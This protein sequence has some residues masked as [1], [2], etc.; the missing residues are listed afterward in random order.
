[1]ST[2]EARRAGL[3]EQLAADRLDGFEA[4]VVVGAYGR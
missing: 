3:R 1:M 2:N 4:P